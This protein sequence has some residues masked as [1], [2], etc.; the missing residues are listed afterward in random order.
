MFE[1]CPKCKLPAQFILDDVETA[2]TRYVHFAG[3]DCLVP[4]VRQASCCNYHQKIT[5]PKKGIK[6]MTE[7]VIDL[8]VRVGLA[9]M[10]LYAAY[11]FLTLTPPEPKAKEKK[12]Q[13]YSL[14][15]LD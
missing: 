2:D 13:G 9:L 11:W 10:C 1:D 5:E 12:T 6:K 8:I 14:E 3:P 7:D 4:K 15:H